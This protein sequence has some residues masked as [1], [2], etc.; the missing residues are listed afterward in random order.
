[1]IL[2]LLKN[3]KLCPRNCGVDRTKR[4]G[5]CGAGEKIRVALVSLHK[6]EEPC[7]V[8][9]NGAGTVFFSHCNLKCVYCQN[10]EISSGGRGEEISIERLAE[11]FLEQQA[12]GAANVELV[13][14]TH[15]VPQIC[16]ALDLAKANGLK[17]PVVYNTSAYENLSTLELLR[18]R[19][20]IFLPDLK[21][22]SDETA[23]TFSRA[24][25]YFNAAS[26]AIRKM[27]ELV[28]APAF[29][30]TG[31]MTRGVIVR[32]LI[33]PNFRRDSIKI[34]DWLYENFGDRIF[35][36]LMNQYTPVFRAGE[37]KKISRR[38]TTF[39]YDSVVKHAVEIGVEN[40]YIQI[41]RTAEE[42]FI[43]RFDGSGVQ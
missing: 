10:F 11:I 31:N 16:A 39:E 26:A 30:A 35:I 21:Y 42:K 36:S 24:P 33:L 43:P 41:G 19:V 38:L 40:C 6:W 2:D 28:G 1:M 13:T 37:Y 15:Y 3:C 22:F 9:E 4:A 12:R 14:P 5:F 27:V 20:D 32:H 7:L 29:S 17:L 18:D 23:V 25:N 34:L 8:G